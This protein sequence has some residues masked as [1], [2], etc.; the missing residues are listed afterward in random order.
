MI[1]ILELN[2]DFPFSVLSHRVMSDSV[3]LW[4]AVCQAPLPMGILQ[5]RILEW[6]AMPSCRASLPNSRIEPRCST[7]QEDSLP[8]EPPG[9][10]FHS[11]LSCFPPHQKH[12]FLF[13]SQI[14]SQ[15]FINFPS[16]KYFSYS[17]HLLI[18]SVFS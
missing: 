14:K 8:S 16:L 17:P 12:P 4:T 18:F 6:V 9:K 1:Y 7:L 3:T 2:S 10:S 15:A 5:A 11:L 13:P